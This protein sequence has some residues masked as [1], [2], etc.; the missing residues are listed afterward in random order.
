MKTLLAAIALIATA[1]L[2]SPEPSCAQ[3]Y[4]Y[5]APCFGPGGCTG[6]CTCIQPGGPG[7]QGWCN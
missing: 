1:W 4:C 7:T 5:S 6:G 2:S 3:G